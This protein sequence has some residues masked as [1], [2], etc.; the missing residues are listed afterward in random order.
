MTRTLSANRRSP[1]GPRQ[2]LQ[3]AVAFHRQGRFREA[4]GFYQIVLET[5]ARHFD[6]LYSLGL[7][8]LQQN[9]FDDAAD[10]FRRAT[11]VEKGS[12]EAHH[13]LAIALTGVGRSGE[14]IRRYEKALAI[15]PDFAEAHNN[16]GYALQ[17]L[18]RIEEAIAQY[19]K[20]LAIRPVYSE[21]PI[22][23]HAQ[24]QHA[25][26]GSVTAWSAHFE[27]YKFLDKRY[28]HLGAF[29]CA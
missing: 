28:G 13:S 10:L 17:A 12:A 29:N 6:S 5:E 4:E 3:Q 2:A 27:H 8:K 14:A 11:K 7:I 15:R 16:L 9:K 25:I 1:V 24:S 21:A 19:Q 26:S 23:I 20:A 18:G 22:N